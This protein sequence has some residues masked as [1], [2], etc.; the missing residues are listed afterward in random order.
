M[1]SVHCP[2]NLLDFYQIQ[3]LRI[4]LMVWFNVLLKIYWKG[5]SLDSMCLFSTA[6][7]NLLGLQWWND[8]DDDDDAYNDIVHMVVC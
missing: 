5:V 7:S 6:T 8:D 2:E 3:V 4:L 1:S